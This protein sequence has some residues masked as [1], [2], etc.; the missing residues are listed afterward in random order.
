MDVFRSRLKSFIYK[1]K[2]LSGLFV[3]L[4]I[5][6]LLT[7]ISMTL[8]VTSGAS[9]LDLS[10]PGFNNARNKIEDSKMTSFPSSGPLGEKDY[11]TFITLFTKEREKLQSLGSFDENT[12]SDEALGLVH[13]EPAP[14]GQDNPPLQ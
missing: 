12:L 10:R 5:T 1:N 7:G 11:Q 6:C 13:Q 2:V 14:Q 8:Y 3:V 9:G 4:A